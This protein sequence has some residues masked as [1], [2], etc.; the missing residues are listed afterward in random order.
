[1]GKNG[2]SIAVYS[3]KSR[4]TG[5]GDSIGNQVELCREYIRVHYGEEALEQVVVFEDAPVIIG[6]K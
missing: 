5:K 1:M 2:E 3:R 6:L 4:F